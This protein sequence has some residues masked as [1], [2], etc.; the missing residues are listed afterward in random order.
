VRA[1]LEGAGFETPDVHTNFVVARTPDAPAHMAEL[2]RR[3]LVVRGYADSLRITVRSPADDDLVL[4]ALGAEAPPAE[5]RSATVFRP[6]IR[7]SL[8]VDGSGRARSVTRDV[9]R[10][11]ELERRAIESGFDLE[12]VADPGARDQDVFGAFDDAVARAGG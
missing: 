8:V 11:R 10:D 12:L 9:A 7:A 2:E 4:Q 3:G 5:R 1:A 6:G